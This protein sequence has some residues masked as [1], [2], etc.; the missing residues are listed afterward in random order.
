MATS[1][2]STRVPLSTNCWAN[3]GPTCRPI[4]AP[5]KNPENESTPM[6]NPCRYPLIANTSM[7]NSRTRSTA[8]TA[9]AYGAGARAKTIA[10]GR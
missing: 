6:T 5:R 3:I 2:I 7:S 9:Q 10:C 8:D 4:R 1:E